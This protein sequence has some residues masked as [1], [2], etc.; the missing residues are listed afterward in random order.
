M[1]KVMKF[2]MWINGLSILFYLILLMGVVYLDVKVFP[3]WEVL[4][5]P[6]LAVLEVI[7]N[8][9]DQTGLKEMTILLYEHLTDQT[10]VVNGLID[11]TIFWIRIHFFVISVCLVETV[12]FISIIFILLIQ[13]LLYIYSIYVN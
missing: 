11:S 2:L 13:K 6:P 9:N 8:S 4:S 3:F 7:K 12:V 1:Y 10:Q 5:T